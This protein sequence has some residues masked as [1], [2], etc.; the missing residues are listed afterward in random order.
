MWPAINAVMTVARD[1]AIATVA[2]ANAVTNVNAL[3]TASSLAFAFH[4]FAF[5][6]E[7]RLTL[8]C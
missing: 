6:Y 3:F 2:V 8:N 4:F 5:H 7:F 1:R